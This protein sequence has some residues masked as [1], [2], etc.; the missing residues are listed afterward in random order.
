[1]GN[2]ESEL[3]TVVDS[4]LLLLGESPRI[5]RDE[6]FSSPASSFPAVAAVSSSELLSNDD[7]TL[8]SASSS[9]QQLQSSS[10]MTNFNASSITDMITTDDDLPNKL[11]E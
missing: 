8:M 7:D 4:I 11:Q 6:H 2:F 9:L 3:F 5:V 1:M 10:Q